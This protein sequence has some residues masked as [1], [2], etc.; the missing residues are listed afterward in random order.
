MDEETWKNVV[1]VAK[2]SD[3]VILCNGTPEKSFG[4]GIY[5][6]KHDESITFHLHT[7]NKKCFKC[8]NVVSSIYYVW[9]FSEKSYKPVCPVCFLGPGLQLN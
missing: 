9:I 2:T 8:E 1:E 6:D 3:C 5:V 7:S 4:F